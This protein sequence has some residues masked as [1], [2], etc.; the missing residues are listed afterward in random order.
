MVLSQIKCLALNIVLWYEYT[1][2]DVY[3]THLLRHCITLCY[4][5]CIIHHAA[6]FTNVINFRLV[7][8]PLHFAPNSVV[9][10]VQIWIVESHMSG[11]MKVDVS[12]YGRLIDSRAWSAGSSVLLEDKEL[13]RDLTH[14]SQ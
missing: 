10:R 14:D 6:Q 8:V 4:K 3:A 2:G 13:A 7:H 11:E 12:H 1:H 9:N 5:P